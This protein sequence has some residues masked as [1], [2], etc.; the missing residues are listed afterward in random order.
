MNN[1]IIHISDLHFSDQTNLFGKPNKDSYLTS[2]VENENQ[3]IEF[4]NLFLDKVKKVE[5]KNK[6]IV[7]TGDITNIAEQNEFEEAEKII[8]YIV[9]ELK[10]DK[11]NILLIPGDHDVHR[12]TIKHELRNDKSASSEL[13]NR[14]KLKN[15]TTFYKKI[16]DEEFKPEVLIF[17]EI[18]IDSI[19]LLGVNSNYKVDQNGGH[20]FLDTVK[21]ERELKSKKEKYPDKELILCLHHNLEG[22]HEDTNFGQW[23]AENKKNLVTLFERNNIKCILNGNEHTPNSKLLANR[24]EIVISDCGSLSSRTSIDASFKIYHI[25]DEEKDLKL[26]NT[27]YGL[28]KI[29]GKNETNY[30]NWVSVAYEDIRELEREFF[31]LKKSNDFVSAKEDSLPEIESQSVDLGN[32]SNSIEQSS[33]GIITAKYENTNIQ[34][35]LY[36]II[37]EK[38]L[39]HQG[40]FHWSETSRAHNWIDTARLLE[41][42]EDLYFIKNSII[43]VLETMELIKGTDIIIGL[44]YEGNI[45]SSNASIKY[46][47]PY[48]YLPYTYRWDDHNNFEKELNYD[49]TD[50]NYKKVILIT[51][52]VNDGRTIR[53]LVGKGNRHKTFFDNVEKIIVVSLFYTGDKQLNSDIL[54]Y[55]N[56]TEKEKK[57][58]EDVNNLEFYTIQQLKI[59]KCPYGDNYKEECFILKDNLHC[60]H[61]FYTDRL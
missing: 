60:V 30:G 28:R 7:I 41:N 4:I 58:D 43:D 24:E 46:P 59:E 6:Y 18:A 10:I 51:D 8:S 15:F 39:F 54:N 3:N 56:L 33:S 55:R 45:I 35:K 40:H 57:G 53:K 27:I 21:F 47:I 32:K 12:D 29:N 37:K 38:K 1:I 16:K 2:N 42:K 44:G 49:N 52:V 23:N 20:G 17:D 13:I 31:V 14:S 5:C 19:V 22:E 36:K 11:K 48:T 61:K 34:N 9:S 50:G 25:I 26:K